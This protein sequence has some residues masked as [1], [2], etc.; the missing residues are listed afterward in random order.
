MALFNSLI[1]ICWFVFIVVWFVFSLVAKRNI[2]S[3]SKRQS[4]F[5]R[6]VTII[7]VIW[8]LK[9][10]SI[11]LIANANILSF[12][13]FVRGCG[14]LICGAGIAFAIWARIHIG[15][16]W[17]MPMSE[18]QKPELVITG[19]Y[20]LVRHPIYTG[21]CVAMIGSMLTQGFLWLIYVIVLGGFF[22]HSAKKEERSMLLHFP[23]KYPGYM[24]RTKMFIPFIF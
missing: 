16:N 9:I 4:S 23:D 17:G 21:L 10:I 22:I 24:K 14:V 2:Q 7:V 11:R 5:I 19:P 12:N 13:H 15:K 20:R 18:K 6:F 3:N 8:L 1:K